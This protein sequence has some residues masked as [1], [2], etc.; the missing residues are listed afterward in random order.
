M[1]ALEGTCQPLR[2]LTA[3]F[4]KRLIVSSDLTNA[5]HSERRT[6]RAPSERAR[7]VPQLSRQPTTQAGGPEPGIGEERA[8]T[9]APAFTQGFL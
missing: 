3:S 9:A 4:V 6:R 7:E 8:P 5:E 1:S 2:A